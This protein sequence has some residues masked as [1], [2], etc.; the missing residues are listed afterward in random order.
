[1][2]KVF[3][4]AIG[5]VLS[6][7]AFSQKAVPTQD[8]D[9]VKYVETSVD[10]NNPKDYQILEVTDGKSGEKFQVATKKVNF[11]TAKKDIPEGAMTKRAFNSKHLVEVIEKNKD[12]FF[13]K[14]MYED[15]GIYYILFFPVK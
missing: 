3:L 13:V 5:L 10:E 14:E 12:K 1:M 15:G 9:K 11:R 7:F 2:K 6:G 8:L 4:F